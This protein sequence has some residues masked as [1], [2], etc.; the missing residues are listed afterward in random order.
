MNGESELKTGYAG[1]DV[2]NQIKALM[3]MKNLVTN[4][5][6]VNKGQASNLPLGAIVQTN[7]LISKNSVKPV[8]SGDLPEELMILAARQISNQKILMKAAKEKDL[9]IAFNAFLNDTLMTLPIDSATELYK[10]ML[11]GIR[12]HLIYYCN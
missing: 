5:D 12:S 11:S 9:D 8:V 10:E 3:G 1:T 6:A 7:A 4:V 2:V